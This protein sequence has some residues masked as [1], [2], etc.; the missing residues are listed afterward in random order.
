MDPGSEAGATSLF[1]RIVNGKSDYV[2]QQW[3]PSPFFSAEPTD[4]GLIR[5]ISSGY[6]K[7]PAPDRQRGVVHC[8]PDALT[9]Q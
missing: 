4:P 8:F 7:A 9:I 6:R 3:V 2:G 1:A 5:P